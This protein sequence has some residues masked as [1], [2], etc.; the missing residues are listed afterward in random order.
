M[1]YESSEIAERLGLPVEPGKATT[2]IVYQLDMMN[3]ASFF[4]AEHFV[5]KNKDTI[6]IANAKTNKIQKVFN[7]INTLIAPGMSAGRS[8]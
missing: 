8:F 4:L 6:L 1:R 5:M 7:L 2:P 3:P